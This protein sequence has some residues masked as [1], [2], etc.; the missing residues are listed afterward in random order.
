MAYAA[1]FDLKGA[2]RQRTH[3]SRLTMTTFRMTIPAGETVEVLISIPEEQVWFMVGERH[4]EITYNVFKHGCIKDDFL[5]F[6]PT[7]IGA[8]NVDVPYA[9]P[10]MAETYLKETFINTDAAEQAFEL[11]IFF[12]VVSRVYYEE[13]KKEVKFE[14]EVKAILRVIW[15]E[16]GLTE[17]IKTVK[18]WMM[19]SPE[20]LMAVVK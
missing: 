5:A 1:A 6:E 13:F 7:L 20:L 8:D 17:K 10:F 9:I 15:D 12:A 11:T 14:E 16:M 2:V 19:E 4:G 3:K 18:K